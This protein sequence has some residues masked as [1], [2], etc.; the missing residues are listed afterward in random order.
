M[1]RIIGYAVI[2]TSACV[3]A[4]AGAVV[5]PPVPRTTPIRAPI[6][7]A[8]SRVAPRPPTGETNR[9]GPTIDHALVQ[10]CLTPG[11]SPAPFYLCAPGNQTLHMSRSPIRERTLYSWDG[12]VRIFP[13]H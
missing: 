1:H 12:P 13:Q 4:Y 5:P 9:T 11:A 2:A 8:D 10:S 7:A 6:G 3:V